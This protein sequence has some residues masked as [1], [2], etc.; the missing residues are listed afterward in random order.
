[1]GKWERPHCSAPCKD[2]GNFFK[3]TEETFKVDGMVGGGRLRNDRFLY[4]SHSG[5]N[6]E[7]GL[8]G[9]WA[10]VGEGDPIG[11]LLAIPVAMI[12]SPDFCC[13]FL[14]CSRKHLY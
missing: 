6:V 12:P 5:Y 13:L 4:E 10:E 8:D 3:R 2:F 11:F 9:A 7:N 14:P 1:M